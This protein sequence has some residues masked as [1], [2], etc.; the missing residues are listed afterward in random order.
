MSHIANLFLTIAKIISNAL[1]SGLAIRIKDNEIDFKFVRKKDNERRVW[2]N[3]YQNA[4][5]YIKDSAQPVKVRETDEDIELKSTD[6]LESY[7]QMDFINR[8]FNAKGEMHRKMQQLLIAN[9]V[10][11]GV[12]AML[13]VYSLS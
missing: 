8:A 7:M 6:Y 2:E 11:V 12:V 1:G 13:V 10:A 5:V 3:H 9:L 4:A